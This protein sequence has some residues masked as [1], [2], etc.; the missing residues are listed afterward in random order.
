MY[1][2]SRKDHAVLEDI[3][4]AQ[5]A[6]VVLEWVDAWQHTLERSLS[7][8]RRGGDVVRLEIERVF[9]FT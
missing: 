5:R 9:C 8:F 3:G 1:H 2:L 7:D 4:L 6:V